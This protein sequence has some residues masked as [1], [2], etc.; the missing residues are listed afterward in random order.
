PA[1]ALS[2]TS[3]TT[4]ATIHTWVKWTWNRAAKA[5]SSRHTPKDRSLR[6]RTFRYNEGAS[7]K[8]WNAWRD[9]ARV[10]TS[11]GKTG[12]KGQTRLKDCASDAAAES[13]L[14]KMIAKKLTEGYK[15]T[16]TPSKAAT[17]AA[18]PP[19]VF[20]SASSLRRSL[21]EALAENPDDLA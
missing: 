21:E 12:T 3:S 6:M 5:A 2:P 4:S 15:E 13:E 20:A 7:D 10:Y 1:F 17:A 9:G 8:F 11:F 18:A 16:T 19:P 14:A